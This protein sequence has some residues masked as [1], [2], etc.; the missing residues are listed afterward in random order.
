MYDDNQ[1]IA[2]ITPQNEN[3][4]FLK[5]YYNLNSS[6]KSTII[7]FCNNE[8]DITNALKFIRKNNLTFRLSPSIQ[9]YDFYSNSDIDIIIDIGKINSIDIN[10]FEETVTVGGGCLLVNVYEKLANFNYTIPG[11]LSSPLGISDFTTTGGLGFAS[12]FLGLTLDNLQEVEI[13]DYNCRKL[14]VNS[15]SHS[16]LFWAIKGTSGSNYGIITSLKYKLSSITNLSIFNITWDTIYAKDIMAYWQE[17]SYNSDD[18]LTSNIVLKKT[19]TNRVVFMCTG[20]F[21]GDLKELTSLL[22]PLLSIAKPIDFDC[23]NVPYYKAFKLL[24]NDISISRKIVNTNL[25]VYD[26]FSSEAIRELIQCIKNAPNGLTHTIEILPV[27]GKIKSIPS[28]E[29]SFPYRNAKF[30]ININSI[31]ERNYQKHKCIHWLRQL[32]KIISNASIM[33]PQSYTEYYKRLQKIKFIYDSTN[34]FNS[35]KGIKPDSDILNDLTGDIIIPSSDKYDIARKCYNL[36]FDYHPMAIIYCYTNQDIINVIAWA[37]EN[38]ISIRPRCTGY[39]FEAL[40]LND[41]SIIIDIS[42]MNSFSIDKKNNTVTVGAGITQGELYTKLYKE[43]YGFPGGTC[44]ELGLSGLV[45]GGGLGLSSRYYG[46]TCDTLTE[47][48]LI[49]DK[50]NVITANND[51][52]KNLFWACR[53]AGYGNFGIFTKFTFKIEPINKITYIHIVWP[54]EKFL[55]VIDTYQNLIPYI[56]QR[57]TCQLLLNSNLA[58]LTGY[59]YVDV[60]TTKILLD[61]LL[62]LPDSL[63]IQIDTMNFIDAITLVSKYHHKENRFKSSSSFIYNPLPQNAMN[64]ILS[65]FN[66]C[67]KNTI[68]NSLL[69]IPLGGKIQEYK[70]NNTSFAHRNAL[71]IIKYLSVW[72]SPND[73]NE[74]IEWVRNFRNSMLDYSQFAYPG[75]SDIDIIPHSLNYYSNNVLKLK[76]V[77]NYYNPSD[78]FDFSQSISNNY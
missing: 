61:R 42:Y 56:D 24:S 66:N 25:Y 23:S 11:S 69:F 67:P 55:Q 47:L 65:F 45:S 34:F 33:A 8:D 6:K 39:D 31:C 21:F 51:K 15:I 71:F 4:E 49:N 60:S 76:E 28:E 38:N 75:F 27:G 22:K 77:K 54:K 62:E 52:N 70:N 3:F 53:G 57:I 44:T 73:D 19:N 2:V 68:E 41:S 32:K 78:L 14:I 48:T 12:R 20:H 40:S 18:L 17:F 26:T 59:S 29:S 35:P 7:F 74:N 9:D 5:T 16:N 13:I 36:R 50:G 63:Y 37:K 43:G 72:S 10:C 30:N 1:K 58:S 46:L 64:I